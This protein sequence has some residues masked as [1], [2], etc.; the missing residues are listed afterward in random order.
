MK[1]RLSFLVILAAILLTVGVRTRASGNGLAP[2]EFMFVN[3]ADI[4]SNNGLYHFEYQPDGNL[5]LYTASN[6]P[7][8]ASNTAGTETGATVMQGD[9]NLVIY[10]GTGTPI[11][12]TGTWGNPGAFL[13]L[14]DD[15]SLNIIAAD[16]STVLWTTGPSPF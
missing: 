12:A 9:G 6:I 11:W 14:S 15:G 4:V 1:R 8:F 3:Y 2:G 7:Y 10:D 13:T 16:G 5:V